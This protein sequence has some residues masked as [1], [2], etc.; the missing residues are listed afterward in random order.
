MQLEEK[1]L[2]KTKKWWWKT[3]QAAAFPRFLASI[4]NILARL[5]THYSRTVVYRPFPSFSAPYARYGSWWE[6]REGNGIRREWDEWVNEWE[7]HVVRSVQSR[8]LS[9]YSRSIRSS[10]DSFGSSSPLSPYVHSRRGN[11]AGSGEEAVKWRRNPPPDTMRAVNRLRDEGRTG[12]VRWDGY[13]VP[14][15]LHYRC[16]FCWA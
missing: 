10:R 14:L 7:K 8:R 15:S 16:R 6:I 13:P 1:K 11:R 2:M 4:V 9:S 3:W 12:A 5:F